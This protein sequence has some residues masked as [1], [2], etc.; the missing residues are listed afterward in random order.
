MG[1]N[2]ILSKLDPMNSKITAIELANF[3]SIK[4]ARIEFDDTGIINLCGYNDSGKSAIITALDVLFYDAHPNDQVKFIKDGEE[5]FGVGLEFSDGVSINKYKYKDGKSVW[6]MLLGEQVIFTN[7]LDSG[8]AA[9]S[10]VPEVIARY[11][12]VVQDEHTGEKLNVRRNV[13]RLFLIHTTG[14]DNYK[15]INSVLRCDILAESVKRLNEDRNKLQSELFVL[16]NSRDTLSNELSAL[17]VPDE[18]IVFSL[19]DLKEKLEE[20]KFR[21]ELLSAVITKKQ[22]L[23]DLYV[24]DELK[25]VS[26]D[27]YRELEQ[28]MHLLNE[29]KKPVYEECSVVDIERYTL[30]REIIDLREKLR[31]GVYDKLGVVDI[32]RLM[33]LDQIMKLYESLSE[34]VFDELEIVDIERLNLLKE[35]GM[36]YNNWWEVYNKLYQ[37]DQE[38]KQVKGLLDQYAKQYGFTICKNCGTVVGL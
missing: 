11:L 20:S 38:Y 8:V 6:E 2:E 14:G 34:G 30:L 3:M 36:A 1:I 27:R 35:V 25:D 33:L 21:Y 23:D 18:E 5:F 10:G 15:I 4:S 29:M 13:D 19:D 37:A 16:T 17:E 26:L 32:D 7:K 9:I 28:L 31:V 24:Y 12:G 22:E